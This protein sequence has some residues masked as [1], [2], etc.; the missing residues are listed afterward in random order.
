MDVHLVVGGDCKAIAGAELS[1]AEVLVY[2]ANKLHGSVIIKG[3]E[4]KNKGVPVGTLDYW[5]KLHT[6]GKAVIL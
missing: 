3:T 5:F 2:P 4:G 6:A 1:L